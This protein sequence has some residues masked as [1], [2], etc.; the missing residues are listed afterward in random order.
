MGGAGAD[1]IVSHNA[2]AVAAQIANAD[3]TDRVKTTGLAEFVDE[4]CHV[5]CSDRKPIG[6]V[7][8]ISRVFYLL[9]VMDA[10]R[11]RGSSGR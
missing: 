4:Q 3:G 11:P 2:H 6:M 8:W 9:A 5:L 10:V 7:L 1:F